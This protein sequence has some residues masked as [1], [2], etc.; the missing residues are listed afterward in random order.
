MKSTNSYKCVPF[1]VNCFQLVL[2]G[3]KNHPKQLGVQMAATACMYN[4][5]KGELGPKIHPAC[6]Q[7]VVHLTLQAMENFPNHQQVL[8]IIFI[9]EIQVASV[10]L[11]VNELSFWVTVAVS[12]FLHFSLSIHVCKCSLCHSVIANSPSSYFK[13]FLKISHFLLW[14]L[15]FLFVNRSF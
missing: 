8:V 7:Q 14:L 6:L 15:F 5:T 11:S 2:P 9:E 10:Y 12:V 13:T 3:M 1:I 4:L